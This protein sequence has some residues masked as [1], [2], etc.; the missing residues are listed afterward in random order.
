MNMKCCHVGLYGHRGLHG[1]RGH[2][3]HLDNRENYRNNRN[4]KWQGDNQG[5]SE[6]IHGFLQLKI[7]RNKSE[8]L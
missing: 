3:G 7:L 6:K 8:G 4:L 5:V 2:H 1:L